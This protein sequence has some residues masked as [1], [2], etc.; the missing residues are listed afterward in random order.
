MIGV[1]DEGGKSAGGAAIALDIR[2]DENE[3]VVSNSG[4]K[5]R[6]NNGRIG[7]VDPGEKIIDKERNFGGSGRA[8]NNT[9]AFGAFDDNLLLA[10]RSDL[11]RIEKLIESE[12]VEFI[13]SIERD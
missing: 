5:K 12:F 11:G 8:E 10:E 7:I 13:E 6:V 2:M 4:F 1:H 9:F 3:L